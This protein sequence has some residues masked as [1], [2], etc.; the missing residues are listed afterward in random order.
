MNR[1][2]SLEFSPGAAGPLFGLDEADPLAWQ[3]FAECQYTDPEIFFPEQGGSVREAKR[4]CQGCAVRGACLDYALQTDQRFGVWGGLSERERHR[5][6]GQLPAVAVTAPHL[7]RK[8]LHVMDEDNRGAD[9]RCRACKSA[10]GARAW[11]KQHPVILGKGNTAGPRERDRDG[12]FT[13]QADRK[14]AA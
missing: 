14:L 3:D 5:I 2:S 13:S 1:R 12:R 11:R 6:G 4:V 7:C 8:R 10:A 9:G